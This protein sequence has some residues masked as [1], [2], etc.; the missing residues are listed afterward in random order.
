M[1]ASF[2]DF[3]K[4]MKGKRCAVIGMG[5]SNIPLIRLLLSAGAEVRICDRKEEH[6]AA[7][8]EEFRARGAEFSLGEG[9]LS[10]LGDVEVIFKT[11]G[12]RYDVPELLAAEGRGAVVTTETEEGITFSSSSTPEKLIIAPKVS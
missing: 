11:P 8:V 2:A 1:S 3:T 10:S 12:M 6:D 4:D 7:T 5:V 9:Y